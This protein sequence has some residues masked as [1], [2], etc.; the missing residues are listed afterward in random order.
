MRAAIRGERDSDVPCNGCTACCTLVAVRPHRTRRDRHARAH[1][2][3]AV[4]PG[5]GPAARPRGARLRRAGHC[6]MLVDDKCSIYEHR[7]HACRTYDCRVFPAAGLDPAPR[8]SISRRARRWRFSYSTDARSHRA[9]CGPRRRGVPR[10]APRRRAR[11]RHPRQRDAARCARDRDPRSLSG[12]GPGH[13]PE[14]PCVE[15][16][17]AVVRA[18][19]GCRD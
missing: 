8:R 5:T 6:P 11:R 15:P 16:D 12:P 3:R 10:R 2:G 1:P 9:R 13:G 17:P 7:P 18:A 4:V 19:L 14:Q